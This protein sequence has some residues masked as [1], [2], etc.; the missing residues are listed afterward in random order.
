ME[1]M[2]AL[3]SPKVE[4]QNDKRKSDETKNLVFE[5]NTLDT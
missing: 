1:L 3:E 4:S 2:L 5:P